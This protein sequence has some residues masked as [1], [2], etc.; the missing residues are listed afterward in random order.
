[1]ALGGIGLVEAV[2][3]YG[4]VGGLGYTGAQLGIGLTGGAVYYENNPNIVDQELA[5]L[6]ESEGNL[7]PKLQN[8]I[9]NGLNETSVDFV[10][11]RDRA[12]GAEVWDGIIPSK[13]EGAKTLQNGLCGIRLCHVD[14]TGETNLFVSDADAAFAIKNGKPITEPQFLEE[15]ARSINEN[16]VGEDYPIVMHGTHIEGIVKGIRP[17]YDPEYLNAQVYIFGKQGFVESGNI[18][19]MYQRYLLPR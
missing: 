15:L 8:A 5:N 14:S 7:A 10:A 2:G 18:L 13:P 12:E 3:T 9:T 16:Y 11:F 6:A 19:E 1:L 17:T 4:L